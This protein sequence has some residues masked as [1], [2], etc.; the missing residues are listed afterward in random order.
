[1]IIYSRKKMPDF[2]DSDNEDSLLSLA[3]MVK[4]TSLV[5]KHDSNGRV[6]KIKR[7][8]GVY[9]YLDYYNC[10]K[11][12]ETTL[13]SNGDTISQAIQLFKNGLLVQ[14]TMVYLQDTFINK[15]FYGYKF[16]ERRHWVERR[17]NTYKGIFIESRKL[18]YY[19]RRTD[20][21]LNK[22]K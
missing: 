10:E 3:P 13:A 17:Y 5:Q 15:S 21:Q 1:M 8:D 7:A 22:N 11:E 9:V 6:K 18:E 2:Y 12:V 20:L 19:V 16:N 4:D 14:Y